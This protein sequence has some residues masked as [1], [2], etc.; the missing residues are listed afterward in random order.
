MKQIIIV[1]GGFVGLPAAK[2]IADT[3]GKKVCITLID[4]KEYFTFLPRLP[5]ALAR[6]VTKKDITAAYAPIAKKHGFF[7]IQGTVTSVDRASK[8]IHYTKKSGTSHD[9]Q[10]DYLIYSPGSAANY[11]GIQGAAEH[12]LVLKSWKDVETIHTRVDTLIAQA[13]V[14][15]TESQKKLLLSIIVAGAGPSG[16]ESIFA[17]QR[18]IGK[19]IRKEA[20][21][22]ASH[23]SYAL[24][25]GAPQILPGFHQKIVDGAASEVHKNGITL[26][27][28]EPV[29]QVRA[30]HV[31]T[32]HGRSLPAGLI[33][34]TAGIKCQDIPILPSTAEDTGH[35]P[36]VSRSLTIEP[37][38]LA[39]GDAVS[40]T[41]KQFVIP[42]NGQTAFLMAKQ[43]SE[44]IIRSIRNKPFTSFTYRSLGHFLP[45]G[46]TGYIQ[47]GPLIIKSSFAKI[48]RNY[49]YTRLHRDITK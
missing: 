28:G 33:I 16:I 44:N 40:Y 9:L 1:G 25:Q 45:L 41:E 17:L 48:F 13:R 3:L 30:Q 14:A 6:E 32:A 31:L 18:Y 29:V 46:K 15:T 47:L 2:Y 36:V 49:Y 23:V 42:K 20:P 21:E 37:S 43:I 22:L 27:I 5:D 35:C 38:V 19:K 12:C 8:K 4:P 34:W 39:G 10:Y 24:I 11:Y 7:F 26:L